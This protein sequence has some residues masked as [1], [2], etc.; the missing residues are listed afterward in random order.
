MMPTL[1]SLLQSATPPVSP[2]DPS[3]RYY[4]LETATRRIGD[5]TVAYVTRRFVPPATDYDS[6]GTHSFRKNLDR[7]DR[8]AQRHLQSAELYWR[9]CDANGAMRPEEL[10]SDGRQIVIGVPR[11]LLGAPN[12]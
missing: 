12:A 8:L 5:R 3:S 2:F 4:G 7:L 1:D 6:L 11:T 9:L 10:E